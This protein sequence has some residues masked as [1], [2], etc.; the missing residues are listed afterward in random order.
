LFQEVPALGAPLI[1]A[2]FPRAYCDANRGPGELDKAMFS[3][4]LTVP[5]DAPGPRVAAGLG[6]IPRIV[7]D[8][9]EIYRARLSPH[10]AETRLADFYWPY[11]A[12]L[13]ALAD[14]TARRFGLAIIVDCHSMPST[15]SAPD[16]VLGD[17]YGASAPPALISWVQNAFTA[18]GFGVVRNTP[19]AGGYTTA[20]YGRGGGG[21]CALQI[22]VN[23]SLYLEE[24]NMARKPAF[25]AIRQ[26]LNGVLAAMV[27]VS[28]AAIERC[29]P[30]LAAE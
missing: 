16:I 30:P 28:R 10:E 24:E 1:A 20:L 3:G 12:A 6:V 29:A 11:H 5:V 17:R 14:E 25:D 19:Y 21:Y 7:R 8:G 18:A 23:R 22:E 15:P 9:A 2:R 26:R 4:P 13:S 27:A